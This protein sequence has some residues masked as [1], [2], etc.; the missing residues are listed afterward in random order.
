MKLQQFSDAEKRQL[1]KGGL[2]HILV[3]W[4]SNEDLAKDPKVF[5]AGEGCYIYDINGKRYLDSFSSLVTSICGH[6]RPEI[7]DAIVE[8]MEYLEFFPN[9]HDTFNVPLIKLAEKLAKITPGDL[10]V[11]FFVCSGSEANETAI[12][13]ARQYLWQIGQKQRYKVIARRKSYHGTTIVASWHTGF[14]K[15]WEYMEPG[16]PGRLF[17]PDVNCFECALGAE[18]S[19]CNLACLKELVGCL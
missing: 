7:K 14:P 10:E 8:Q 18:F 9:Y 13:M 5:I 16:I 1:I 19:M 6:D 12:K 17:A 4:A 15:L 11:C 2:D 3:H